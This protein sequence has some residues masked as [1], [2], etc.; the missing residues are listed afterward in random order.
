MSKKIP[1]RNNKH[2]DEFIVTPENIINKSILL[3]GASGSGKGS[4][5]KNILYTLKDKIDQVIF[6]SATECVDEDFKGIIPR[7]CVHSKLYMADPTGT[8][9]KE[10][11]VDASR[12]FLEYL[13]ERQE[14][15]TSVHKRATH[16]DNLRALYKKIDRELIKECDIILSKFHMLKKHVKRDIERDRRIPPDKKVDMYSKLDVKTEDYEKSLLRKYLLKDNEHLHKKMRRG[17]LSEDEKITLEYKE[18]NPNLLLIFDD[19]AAELKPLLKIEEIRK[20]F[21]QGRH[22]ST[23]I[24]LTC[25]DDTDLDANLRKQA[26]LNFFTTPQVAFSNFDRGAN[27]HSKE[28]QEAAKEAICEVYKEKH[29]K[30][31]FQRDPEKF[32]HYKAIVPLPK[33][34]FGSD[35]LWELCKIVED[36][37]KTLNKMNKYYDK[38]IL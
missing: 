5:I 10:K 4:I 33:F 28:L 9:K 35:A 17:E 11:P 18:V 3:Y 22:F 2:I 27:R 25:Q 19:Y 6:V 1:L 23:T 24:I 8:K 12:R 7:C 29:R 15:L 37:G 31:I 21:Y 16:I 30:L 13:I 26:Y 36:D 20:L 38:F 14:M 32:F 34:R